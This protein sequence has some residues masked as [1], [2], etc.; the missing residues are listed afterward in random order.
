[1]CDIP[2]VIPETIPEVGD[3]YSWEPTAFMAFG[4]TAAS[5]LQA[6][7]TLHGRVTMVHE[8]HRWFRVEAEFPG[9]VLRE[10]FKY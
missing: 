5:I 9:G 7:V 3:T 10:C 4:I 8:E 2:E 1:M 6:S